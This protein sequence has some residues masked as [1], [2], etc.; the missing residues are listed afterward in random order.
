M[1]LSRERLDLILRLTDLTSLELTDTPE[2]IAALCAR[3]RR[4]DPSDD[5]VPPVAAVCVYPGLVKVAAAELAGAG[6]AVASVVGNFPT[7][8][9]TVAEKVAEAE[10]AIADGATELDLLVDHV[11]FAGGNEQGLSD[12][13][14]AVRAASPGVRLKVILETGA[15]AGPVPVRRAADLALDAGA[16]VL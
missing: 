7:G 11:A 5:T 3:A 10:Q 8:V 12:E 2:S 1:P 16:D 6:I 4:P 15:L 14:A 9:A 13:V